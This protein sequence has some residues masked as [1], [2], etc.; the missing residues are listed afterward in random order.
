M[1]DFNNNATT[2]YG[3]N[4]STT[5]LQPNQKSMTTP[6]YVKI[7]FYLM[8][9]CFIF[10]GLGNIFSIII[11]MRKHFIK[12]ARSP[13][14]ITMAAVNMV[15]VTV[16][17]ANLAGSYY[18]GKNLHSKSI[19]LCKFV[20]ATTGFCQHIESWVIVILTAERLCAVVAPFSL[21]TVFSRHNIS[22]F[23]LIVTLSFL[24]LDTLVFMNS[25]LGLPPWGCMIENDSLSLARQLLTGQIPLAFLI[26]SNTIVIIKMIFKKTKL[27]NTAQQTGKT[28][29]T[30]V[31]L[32]ILTVTVAFIIFTLPFS[33]FLMCCRRMGGS[34]SR[35]IGV[36]M[37]IFPVIN[38]SI[39]FYLYF[40]SSQ[41]FRDEV[42]KELCKIIN[43]FSQFR[44]TPV[45]PFSTDSSETGET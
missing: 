19:F 41:S 34:K 40:C 37:T 32:M 9:F 36:T 2:K 5:I 43:V 8:L 25:K 44:G 27:P 12:T 38:S 33:V 29:N 39:N 16:M 42:K 45:V 24:I 10:G 23:V 4:Y 14:C 6:D 31:T 1:E 17:F 30:K 26:P 35:M 18:T 28:R 3:F 20:R 11:W 13:A 21:K 22:I 15:Y 7:L